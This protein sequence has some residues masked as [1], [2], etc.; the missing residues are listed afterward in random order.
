M[1]KPKHLAKAVFALLVIFSLL[2]AGCTSRPV[3]SPTLPP[4]LPPTLLPTLS[5]TSIPTATM[6]PAS[7]PHLSLMPG[8]FYF[9]L[10]GQPG[11]VFSRNIAGY[12]QIHYETFLDW[13]KAGGSTFVR[14]QLDSM[15]MGY[16]SNGEVD[17]AWARQWE[18]IF[19]RAAAQGI[20]I[21]PCFS[22]WYDWNARAGYSTW[23]SNPLNAAKGGPVRDPVELFRAG[24]PTQILW[25]AWMETLVRRWHDRGNILAWEIFSEVN[26]A[27]NPT[28][29]AGVDFANTAAARIRAADPSGRPV[30]AS[31]AD[32]GTWPNFY[33]DTTIDFINIHPY[34]TSA[35][36]DRNI[37]EGVRQYLAR[38][39]RPVL[40]GESGLSAATPDSSSGG[41][42]IA[43]NAP[44]GISHAIWA[45]IVSGA[46]N[47]RALWW[48]DGVGIYFS[49]LGIPWMEQYKIA[50]LPAVNF[51]QGVDFSGFK[52]LTSASSPAVWGASVGNDHLVLGWFRDAVS[53]PPDWT[54][55]TIPAGQTV[56]ITVPGT[57]ANWQV[58][59]YDTKTGTTKISSASIIRHGSTVTV[60]LPAFQDDI[61]FKMMPG[62]ETAT[63]TPGATNNTNAIAGKWNGTISNQAGTF[64][65]LVELSIQSNCAPGRV[66]GTYIAPR[67][68]CS[69]DL[70]LNEITS[71]HFMFI[72]QNASGGASCI[73]GGYEYLQLLEDGTLSYRYSSQST[74]D[75]STGVLHRP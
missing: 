71:A 8:E 29:S 55:R 35:Q 15:G 32:T 68:F 42:T 23:S 5:P 39:N 19:D 16:T 57:A 12:Q 18:R 37:V 36:L 22:S 44:L 6:T 52:P 25:L 53:E 31:I 21:L 56:T 58:D 26:L 27:S 47:G 10:D 43:K 70:F 64:S 65:T 11:F 46:M 69:G 7:L 74:G 17:E 41:A 33:R 40:I 63:V 75:A 38:Y 9:R 3:P 34:P 61:A 62:A 28:E 60:T 1:S 67:L 50:E 14:I 20:Y 13:S 73:S 49:S 45:G 48:E 4:T 72:E 24:S 2:L 66:C 59:F 54:V 30:T 51:V